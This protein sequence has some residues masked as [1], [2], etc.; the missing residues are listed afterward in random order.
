MQA[1][2]KSLIVYIVAGIALGY[3][4]PLIGEKTYAV[5]LAVAVFYLLGFLMQKALNINEKF[6]WFF[7]N[8]GWEYFFIWFIVWIIF[9]NL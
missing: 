6:N 4:S 9:Y 7:K 5:V 3:L 8:G 2:K 1:D